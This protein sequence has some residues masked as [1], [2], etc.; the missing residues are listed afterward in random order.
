MLRE[1]ARN[2]RTQSSSWQS[3]AWESPGGRVGTIASINGNG[4][5]NI[6]IG[7]ATYNNVAAIASWADDYYVGQTVQVIMQGDEPLIISTP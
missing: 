3:P 5:Y 7:D 4:L 6:T 2:N 1:I